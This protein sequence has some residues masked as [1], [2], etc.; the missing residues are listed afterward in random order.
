MLF[1]HLFSLKAFALIEFAILAVMLSILDLRWLV[2]PN[3]LTYLLL[4]SGLLWNTQNLFT[5]IYQA[6]WG[7]VIAYVFL[8]LLYH[9][10]KTITHR[11]GLGLGDLKLFA[12]LGAWFGWM[13]LPKILLFA[14]L[15]GLF[16][17]FIW[18]ILLKKG[19]Q[20]PFGPA[21]LISGFLQ[22]IF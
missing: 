11:E 1:S 19:P 18:R 22:F 20:V 14:G 10:F 9:G 16:M 2:L 21:L 6:L 5:P 7:V 12:A 15:I 17:A 13:A 3:P 8:W 4:G